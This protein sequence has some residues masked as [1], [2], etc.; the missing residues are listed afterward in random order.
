MVASEP[1]APVSPRK[2]KEDTSAHEYMHGNCAHTLQVQAAAHSMLMPASRR[3][4][5]SG[6]SILVSRQCKWHSH[7]RIPAA[8][9]RV[10]FP[11]SSIPC[12]SSLSLSLSHAFSLFLPV[13]FLLFCRL[14]P[15]PA[16]P[17]LPPPLPRTPGRHPAD[18]VSPARSQPQPASQPATSHGPDA[19]DGLA[20]ARARLVPGL[21]S[22]G[23]AAHPRHAQRVALSLLHARALQCTHNARPHRLWRHKRRQLRGGNTRPA[24]VPAV[25]VCEYPSAHSVHPRA[26][27]K[28]CRPFPIPPSHEG[29]VSFLGLLRL[30]LSSVDT[31]PHPS[32]HTHVRPVLRGALCCA[33]LCYAVRCSMYAPLSGCKW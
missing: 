25:G 14:P 26:R 9:R 5:P 11:L 28:S 19:V 32:M 27:H 1:P 8:V 24:T 12:S 10:P 29:E 7:H 13:F 31:A 21:L 16:S 15:W 4:C 23:R 22:K 33:V 18:A 2:H 30:R 17:P 20:R 6:I 3:S